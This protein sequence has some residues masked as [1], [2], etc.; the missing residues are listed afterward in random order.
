M[1][2]DVLGLADLLG[3][4][5]VFFLLSYRR[6]K[7]HVML[8]RFTQRRIKFFPHAKWGGGEVPLQLQ[9]VSVGG[10]GW[11]GHA[12]LVKLQKKKAKIDRLS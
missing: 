6:I 3:I 5:K 9:C 2:L 7:A 4:S 11:G 1:A 12:Q 10:W 8:N